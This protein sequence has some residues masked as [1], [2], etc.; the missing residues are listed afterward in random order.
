[1]RRSRRKSFEELVNENKQ[2][3]LSD[4]DAIDRIEV[5]IEKRYEMKLFKQAE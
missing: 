3:L 5:R 2:Q 1:M 4:R